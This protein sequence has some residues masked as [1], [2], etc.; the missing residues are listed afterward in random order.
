MPDLLEEIGVTSDRAIWIV[1]SESFQRLHCGRRAWRHETLETCSD[2][3]TA[4]QNWMARDVGFARAIGSE[5]RERQRR[6]VT[7]DG[8]KSV[9]HL[10]VAV[11]TLFAFLGK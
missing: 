5:A 4:W 1:P 6:V 3:E 11:A 10:I 7:V 2:K 8:S 9:E